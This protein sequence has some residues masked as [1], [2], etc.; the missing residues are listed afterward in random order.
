MPQPKRA[1]TDETH[2]ETKRQFME[3]WPILKDQLID[4]MRT[5]GMPE[6]VTTWFGEV[7]MLSP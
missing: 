7:R 2:S 1:V 3:V 6:K 5:H 4:L